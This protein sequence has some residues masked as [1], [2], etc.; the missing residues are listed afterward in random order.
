MFMAFFSSSI[1]R[2]LTTMSIA[3]GALVIRV[4]PIYE[5]KSRENPEYGAS[6]MIS[7]R[8][9]LLLYQWKA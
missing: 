9:R 1:L 2:L 5:E 8:I 6:G 4:D 7:N 3:I